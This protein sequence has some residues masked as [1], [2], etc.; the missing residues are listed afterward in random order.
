MRTIMRKSVIGALAAVS[1]LALSAATASAQ[2]TDRPFIDATVIQSQA[3]AFELAGLRL[4]VAELFP[5][6]NDDDFLEQIEGLEGDFARFGGTLASIDPELAE[7]LDDALDA[8]VD[9]VEDGEDATALIAEA[10]DL[11]AQAYDAVIDS[12][13]RETPAFKGAVLTDLLLGEPGVA[14]GYEEAGKEP[15][16]FS[17]GWAALQ[18]AK[19]LW[20]ELSADADEERRADGDEMIAVIEPLFPSAEP[21]EQFIGNPEEAEAPAQRL[22]GILEVVVDADLYPGRD[23]AALADHLAELTTSACTFY[24]DGNDVVGAETIYAVAGLYGDHLGELV[25]LFDPETHEEVEFLLGGLVQ[26]DDDDDDDDGPAVEDDD[27]DDDD[28]RE[29]LAPLESCE[30]LIVQL[31]EVR[32]VLGG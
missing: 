30:G 18:R 25:N 5:G 4:T 17:M 23:H 32:T 24:A 12:A 8:V 6:E 31:Q 2:Y 3:R 21:P 7:A 13:T 11:L 20:G 29:A 27:D 28:D 9:A 22:V 14:E 10:R 19:E 26:L 15:W 1:T 16:A